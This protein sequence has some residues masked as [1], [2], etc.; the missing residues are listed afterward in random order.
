[1]SKYR[2]ISDMLMLI[3]A[4][5]VLRDVRSDFVV[6]GSLH[7]HGRLHAPADAPGDP[8]A[9]FLRNEND[10][11]SDNTRRVFAFC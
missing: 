5:R 8:R 2:M 11:S 4:K 1:M 3:V 7:L 6:L 9:L 10:A